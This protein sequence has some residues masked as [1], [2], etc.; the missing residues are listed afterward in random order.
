MHT[1]IQS[2]LH[3]TSS[4]LPLVP[5]SQPVLAVRKCCFGFSCSNVIVSLCFPFIHSSAAFSQATSPRIS[6]RFVFMVSGNAF[7]FNGH[8][9]KVMLAFSPF[10][11]YSF[12]PVH[13]TQKLNFAF[14]LC[15]C[16]FIVHFNQ[17]DRTIGLILISCLGSTYT[18]DT[19]RSR[20]W[21]GRGK[22]TMQWKKNPSEALAIR[23]YDGIECIWVVNE[24]L[25][26]NGNA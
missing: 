15:M 5:P 2:S 21:E 9:S 7:L 12:F 24:Q 10:F 19:W 8:K 3:C 16:V 18:R 25:M 13:L 23:M 1:W 14:L 11:T 20:G 17:F 6:F 4:Y 22:F 26:L